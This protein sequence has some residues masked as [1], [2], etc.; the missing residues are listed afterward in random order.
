MSFLIKGET[1][2]A[3]VDSKS[4]DYETRHGIFEKAE[5]LNFIVLKKRLMYYAAA[6]ATGAIL[7]ASLLVSGLFIAPA[8]VTS[9]MAYNLRMSYLFASIDRDNYMNKTMVRMDPLRK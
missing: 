5:R 1:F 3:S 9:L 8:T 6:L 7:A 4:L 2:K